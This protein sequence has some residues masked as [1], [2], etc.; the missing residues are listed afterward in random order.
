MITY[1]IH[2]LCSDCG[3]S[4]AMGKTLVLEDGPADTRTVADTYK[5]KAVPDLLVRLRYNSVRC[6]ESGRFFYQQD[7]NHLFLVPMTRS[8]GTA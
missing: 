7:D 4:H 1:D 5:G 2:A 6:R 3:Q 8:R